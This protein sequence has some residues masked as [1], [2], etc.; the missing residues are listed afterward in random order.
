MA[1]NRVKTS[2]FFQQRC[3]FLFSVCC[4]V[5]AGA[6]FE[7]VLNFIFAAC[8]SYNCFLCFGQRLFR[9][10]ERYRV[11]TLPCRS[12]RL[13]SPHPQNMAVNLNKRNVTCRGEILFGRQRQTLSK[14]TDGRCFAV[15]RENGRGGSSKPKAEGRRLECCKR[16]KLSVGV[17]KAQGCS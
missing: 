2:S 15:G 6:G 16:L 1:H 3:T 11:L 5:S 17:A 12:H 4:R 14:K 7:E 13:Q 10:R 9:E 8:C